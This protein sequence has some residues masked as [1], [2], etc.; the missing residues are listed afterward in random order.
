MGRG[1][2]F[3][4]ILISAVY[5]I[6]IALLILPKLSA[7]SG[8]A[9]NEIGDFFAGVFGPLA[10]LWLVLGYFQQGAELRQNN[11]ALR[12]QAEELRN[13]VEQQ[14]ELVAVTREQVTIEM[15]NIQQARA[16]MAAQ[17]RPLFVVGSGGG[18]HSGNSHEMGFTLT[19]L[20]APV[21]DVSVIF[22]GA[23]SSISTH[24]NALDTKSVRQFKFGF[25]GDGSD[26]G[27]TMIVR[28]MDSNGG[29]GEYRYYIWAELVDNRPALKFI[30][31]VDQEG[32]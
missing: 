10:F 6:W 5:L 25:N 1:R 18:S 23:M 19:N 27:S 9:L 16:A 2:T 3:F 32:A 30:T 24:I 13:A 4:G 31:P 8:L 12:L 20:G 15:E 29:R 17:V 22:E 26:I 7:I 11:E 21:T 28:Y 14:K